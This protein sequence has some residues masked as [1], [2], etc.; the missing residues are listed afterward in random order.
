MPG[1]AFPIGVGPSRGQWGVMLY[2][3]IEHSFKR[4]HE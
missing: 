2:L 3:S 4:K 1:L